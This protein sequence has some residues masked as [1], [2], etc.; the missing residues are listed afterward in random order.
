MATPFP[1]AARALWSRRA[2]GTVVAEEPFGRREIV[3]EGIDFTPDGGFVVGYPS[4]RLAPAGNPLQLVHLIVSVTDSKPAYFWVESGTRSGEGSPEVAREGEIR[5]V[6]PASGDLEKPVASLNDEFFTLDPGGTPPLRLSLSIAPNPFNPMTEIRF[7]LPS[8]GPVN[9]RVYD[10]RGQLVSDLLS[11]DL[12]AGDHEVVWRG[13]DS[14]GRN[15]AS[16][17]YF[18]KLESES[19]VL[20]RKMMRVW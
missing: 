8:G 3:G 9:L 17:V 15:V 16:G 4:R 18:S 19:G 11:E 14:D 6:P 12:A 1:A 5:L 7:S 20:L 2:Q 13:T 10:A